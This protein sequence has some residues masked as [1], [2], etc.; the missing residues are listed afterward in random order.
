MTTDW[1]IY[2]VFVIV[3]AS[4]LTLVRRILQMVRHAARGGGCGGCSLNRSC[5]TGSS[6]LVT[7]EDL[8]RGLAAS[9]L[10]KPRV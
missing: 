3:G 8:S 6:P 10:Y 9:A 4:M 1:Q 2:V 7:V 5:T